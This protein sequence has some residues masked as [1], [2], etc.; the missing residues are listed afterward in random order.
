[1][2]A[3]L[4]NL[5]SFNILISYKMGG[6]SHKGVRCLEKDLEELLNDVIEENKHCSRQR[7]SCKDDKSYE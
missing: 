5:I 1:M 3:F 7:E 2:V 4:R 6:V